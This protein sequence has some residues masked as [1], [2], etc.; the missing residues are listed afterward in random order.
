MTPD[1]E[2]RLVDEGLRVKRPN[3]FGRAMLPWTVSTTSE[4]TILDASGRHVLYG[5]CLG[6]SRYGPNREDRAQRMPV[7]VA[8]VNAY[9]PDREQRIWKLVEAAR[10][11]VA[12]FKM[13]E[14]ANE[15]GTD[16]WLGLERIRAALAP[17]AEEDR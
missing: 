17:F 5:V 13:D 3:P 2:D 1:T 12:M 8:A 7:I 11:I 4:D 10:D 16:A 14:A 9:D 15:P 6:D